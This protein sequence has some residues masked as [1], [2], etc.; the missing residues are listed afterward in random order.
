MVEDQSQ[1]KRTLSNSLHFNS[2]W[3]T[4]LRSLSNPCEKNNITPYRYHHYYRNCFHH[5]YYICMLRHGRLPAQDIVTMKVL[6]TCMQEEVILSHGHVKSTHICIMF[7]C[8]SSFVAT[9]L[10]Q[11]SIGKLKALRR[12]MFW[13]IRQLPHRKCILKSNCIK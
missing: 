11:N 6:Y 3:R 9:F 12:K 7:S 2:T 8:T 5:Y 4:F 1:K 10:P 13:I